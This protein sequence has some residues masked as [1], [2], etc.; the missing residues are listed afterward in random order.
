MIFEQQCTTAEAHVKHSAALHANP[1]PAK[2]SLGEDTR[3]HLLYSNPPWLRRV[4]AE[5]ISDDQLL[6]T[7][8]QSYR[9]RL[10]DLPDLPESCRRLPFKAEF[11]ASSWARSA[12]CEETSV[13]AA[14]SQAMRC[15]KDAGNVGDATTKLPSPTRAMARW[16]SPCPRARCLSNRL[17][18]QLP[19][20]PRTRVGCSSHLRQHRIGTAAQRLYSCCSL[21]TPRLSTA[22]NA[23]HSCVLR[24]AR[25]HIIHNWQPTHPG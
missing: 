17:D 11:A 3:V 4:I 6:P 8:T 14:D 2:A 19:C 21:V 23:H 18:H 5:V 16:S 13:A 25:S 24:I 20:A 9:R 12:I 10:R 15:G 1:S 22:R 7:S